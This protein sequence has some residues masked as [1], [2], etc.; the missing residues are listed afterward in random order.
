MSIYALGRKLLTDKTEIGGRNYVLN[1]D[2]SVSTDSDNQ[3]DLGT[4]LLETWQKLQGRQITLSAIFT[5]SNFQFGT[6]GRF[7]WEAELK[8]SNGG[9]TYIGIWKRNPPLNSSGSEML[10]AT[11]TVP[12]NITG[13]S[14][15]Q[16]YLLAGGNL[17]I[18]HLKLEVGEVA[19]DWSPAPEDVR[20][21]I[22]DL[23]NQI[24]QLKKVKI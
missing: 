7:G 22:R 13:I 1:S 2:K 21:Q 4:V 8:L 9:D 6:Q 23:Q 20:S 24:N 5:W 17:K 3:T 15:S 12:Q 11:F 10:Q 18:E 16:A 14:S 19:T